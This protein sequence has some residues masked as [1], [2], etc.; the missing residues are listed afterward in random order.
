[1]LKVIVGL[2][3][4]VLRE[5]LLVELSLF[6]DIVLEFWVL[7]LLL[8]GLKLLFQNVGVRLYSWRDRCRVFFWR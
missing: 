7:Q 6:R 3:E 2:V 8:E 1:M 4:F 5:L